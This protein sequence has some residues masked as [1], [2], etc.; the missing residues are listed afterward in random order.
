MMWSSEK[1]FGVTLSPFSTSNSGLLSMADQAEAAFLRVYIN[2]LAS[3]SLVY[4]DDYQQPPANSLK[5]VPVLQ[6]SVPAPPPR[7]KQRESSSAPLSLTFKS[8]K[9]AAS[10]TIAVHP[11]DT[12]AAVKAA[13][14]SQPGG[15]PVDAQRLLLKGKAL[16]DAKLVKE[17]PIKDG[18]TVNLVLKTVAPAPTITAS[19]T[20]PT[21]DPGK[22]PTLSLDPPAQTSARKHQRIPSVVLSPSPSS[23]TV[24]TIDRDIMLTLDASTESL[25]AK[26]LSTYHTAIAEPEFWA[27]LLAFFRSEFKNDTDAQTA[28][29]DFILA[30]KS[31]LTASEIAKIR[32]HVG[33]IG[34]AGT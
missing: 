18:D 10:Y 11:T 6:I 32:D 31:T 14:S 23:E 25:P 5:K 33:V 4:A 21:M 9:P 1:G 7:K 24:P 13:L 16:A 2:T 3:Q 12:I 30:S 34:M 8:L 20:P 26:E 17:Y 15:P 29:E 28:F 19:S 22:L 27:R